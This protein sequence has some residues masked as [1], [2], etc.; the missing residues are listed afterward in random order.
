MYLKRFH[1]GA[2]ELGMLAFLVIGLLLRF[3]LISFNWPTTNSDEAT[4]G[5]MALH[6]AFNG[7]HPAFFYGQYY[8]GPM[9]A[10][11]GA[12]L[13]HIFPPSTFTLRLGLLLLFALFLICIY[14]LTSTLYTKRLALATVG[15]LSL[16]SIDVILRQLRGI[17]GYP[18]VVFLGSLIALLVA[19]LSLS[20]HVINHDLSPQKRRWRLLTYG[21]LGL[22]I[23]FTLWTT[24]LI[25]PLL[26]TSGLTLL[27]FCREELFKKKAF[28]CLLFGFIIG[29]FPMILY[30]L[31][32]TLDHSS[33]NILLDTQHSSADKVAAMH[34]PFVRQLIGSLLIA[35][36]AITGANPLCPAD[37][38]PLFGPGTEQTLTCVTLQGSW[39][40]GYLILWGCAVFLAL[41]ALWSYRTRKEQLSFEE[42]SSL[43]LQFNRLML[44]VSA[45]I[46]LALYTIS[47]ASIL[48]P[49]PTARY[50]ICLQIAIPAVLWPLWQDIQT[51]T[52]TVRKI[53][54]RTRIFS[55]FR[56]VL[57]L[58]ITT[59][60]LI[61]TIRVLADIPNAQAF[62]RQGDLLI[63]KLVSLKARHIYS[64][65][66]TCNRLIFQSNE[67]VICSVLNEKLQ[68]GKDR[69]L[70]YRR[71]VNADPYAAYVFPLDSLY[72]A[73]FE[74][75]M[76]TQKSVL[77]ERSVFEGYVI[78]Q[79][80]ADT[81]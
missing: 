36:P 81:A 11:I 19:R 13:F 25:L 37:V 42:R 60:Y 8:M 69:Y 21:F 49:Q 64:D 29:A 66:W 53:I 23:G 58:F 26:A 7:D 4:I 63:N 14:L 73:T 74:Q 50:L 68:R 51:V 62:H 70:P 31:T 38:F 35:L 76:L 44:L 79:P 46:T 47:P 1:I 48:Y 57:L 45:G 9:E 39:S 3:V 65:Y 75:K 77:F 10:Y 33:L 55:L 2:Y 16:G 54:T 34:L 52:P 40:L 28:L 15:V 17:G 22:V 24:Q 20:S 27:L 43:I 12:V 32:T 67:R 5:L 18:E 30:N 80:A 71:A 78:Y 6:I 72:A 56:T 61:G 59:T 41:T